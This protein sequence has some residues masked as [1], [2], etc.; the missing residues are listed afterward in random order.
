MLYPRSLRVESSSITASAAICLVKGPFLWCLHPFLLKA[1]QNRILNGREWLHT[2]SLQ[3]YMC[4][5]CVWRS[6]HTTAWIWRLENN[7]QD[8]YLSF[9]NVCT[10][11][12]ARI[13]ATALAE[14]SYTLRILF[15]DYIHS[16]N[17]HINT[18][19]IPNHCLLRNQRKRSCVR[20]T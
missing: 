17:I 16:A 18:L 20:Y 19:R 10:R 15:L 13:Q 1:A 4:L 2:F 9:Q 6:L 5:L 11:N 14:M 7:L 12:Q 3:S 8:S